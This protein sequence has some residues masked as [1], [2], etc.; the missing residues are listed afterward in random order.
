[1]YREVDKTSGVDGSSMLGVVTVSFTA[2]VGEIFVVVVVVV[3]TGSADP[4]FDSAGIFNG[5]LSTEG[6]VTGKLFGVEDKT[7]VVRSEL[8]LEDVDFS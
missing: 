6:V 3:S 8:G 2:L 4:F 7:D 1:M 5:R